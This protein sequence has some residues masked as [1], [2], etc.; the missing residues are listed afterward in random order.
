M[1]SF[2]RW[3]YEVQILKRTH[4]P[5]NFYADKFQVTVSSA[6]VGKGLNHALWAPLCAV[7]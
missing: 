1:A 3:Y 2:S 5:M 7:F 6:F 4:L